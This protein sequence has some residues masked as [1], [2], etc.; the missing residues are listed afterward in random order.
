MEQPDLKDL[1]MVIRS[2][3]TSSPGKMTISQILNEYLNYEGCNLPY[4]HL[5]F[6]TIFELLGNMNDVLKVS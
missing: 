4:K 5:G 3:L 6:K 1:K 2:I